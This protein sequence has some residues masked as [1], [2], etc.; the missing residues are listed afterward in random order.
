MV[1]D[2]LQMSWRG[3][4][5]GHMASSHAAERIIPAVFLEWAEVAHQVLLERHGLGERE[6][7]YMCS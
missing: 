4:F 3:R 7:S 6:G 2:A 1:P 5:L